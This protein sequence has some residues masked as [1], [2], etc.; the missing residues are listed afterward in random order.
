MYHDGSVACDW[1]DMIVSS[2]RIKRSVQWHYQTCSGQQGRMGWSQKAHWSCNI[3][4]KTAF[5]IA[6]LCS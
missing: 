1:N 5:P 6:T 2:Q 3:C 4:S